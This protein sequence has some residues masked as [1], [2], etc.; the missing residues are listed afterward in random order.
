MRKGLIANTETTPKLYVY[1]HEGEIK[2]VIISKNFLA[3]DRVIFKLCKCLN[4]KRLPKK[5]LIQLVDSENIINE[6]LPAVEVRKK[7][8]SIKSSIGHGNSKLSSSVSPSSRKN[9][10]RTNDAFQLKQKNKIISLSSDLQHE[11]KQKK[12][13]D[14]KFEKQNVKIKD[15]ESNINAHRIQRKEIEEQLKNE[16][17]SALLR[18]YI[19]SFLKNMSITPDQDLKILND[20]FRN[21]NSLQELLSVLISLSLRLKPKWDKVDGTS[22]WYKIRDQVLGHFGD[23]ARVRIYYCLNTSRLRLCYKENEKYEKRFEKN[24]TK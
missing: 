1:T 6:Y 16:Y 12:L 5:R 21:F 8:Q 7:I 9:D 24:L 11:K 23:D 20:R 18:R 13:L 10:K 15:L 17:F 4:I 3:N 22:S 2:K 19:E 14:E